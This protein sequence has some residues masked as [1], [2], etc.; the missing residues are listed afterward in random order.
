MLDKKEYLVIVGLILGVLVT[1]QIR[2]VI[3]INDLF[4]R[5]RNSNIFEELK[6]S[7]DKNDDL[8][9]EIDNLEES[10]EKLQDQNLA[11]ESIE[12][13]IIEYKKLSGEHPIFGPGISVKITGNIL[14]PWIV[15]LINEF[16]NAG[17]QAVDINGIRI[18][19][20][21]G[22]ID[23]MPNGQLLLDGNI[24]TSPFIFSVIGDSKNMLS[25]FELSGGIFDRIKLAFPQ[26]II[27]S[28]VHDVIQ[29]N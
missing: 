25:I 5:D 16:F 14:A 20:K 3:G 1:M 23:T 2:S 15:D 4:E 26:A 22:G 7:K 24:L 21:I 6:I 10:L 13:D 28:K 29:M 11:L 19:N 27:T 17:A 12:K 18:T 8:R 9:S